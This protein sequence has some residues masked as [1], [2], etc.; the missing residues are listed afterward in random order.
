[1]GTSGT[2][3]VA[4][5]LAALITGWASTAAAAPAFMLTGAPTTQPVGHY[6]LCRELP[7]E[8]TQVSAR[9]GPV[10]LSRELWASM[11]DINNT[12]N[13]TIMPATDMEIW[14]REEIWSYPG[15]F[16]DCEDYVLEKRRQLMEIGVPASSL[17]ITVVRQADGS[18]HAVLTVRTHLGDFILDNLEP[19]ILPWHET[20]YRFLKRQSEKNSGAWVSIN[21]GRTGAVGSVR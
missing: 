2:R 4:A 17:L 13:T 9:Q 10:K 3:F 1:M 15:N 16:A 12:V 14:G 6:E 5:V 7:A 18:G 19:R 11:V 8:C 21:D 20:D